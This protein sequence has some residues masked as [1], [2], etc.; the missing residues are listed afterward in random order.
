MIMYYIYLGVA[1]GLE[2]PIVD[3]DKASC[4]IGIQGKLC[5]FEDC[6]PNCNK[7]CKNA[8]FKLGGVCLDIAIGEKC[9]C[10][11]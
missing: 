9:C 5:C 3:L 1:T 8:G 7:D 4:F 11:K 6:T 10:Y 2:T